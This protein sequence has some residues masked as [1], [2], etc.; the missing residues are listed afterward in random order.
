MFTPDVGSANTSLLITKGSFEK[1]TLISHSSAEAVISLLMASFK[2][3]EWEDRVSKNLV[4]LRINDVLPENSAPIKSISFSGPMIEARDILCMLLK[5]IKEQEKGGK[6]DENIS[7]IIYYLLFN[8]YEPG[9][10]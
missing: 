9:L 3:S 7:R 5:G 4:R 10:N 6:E 1:D 2:S 8:I